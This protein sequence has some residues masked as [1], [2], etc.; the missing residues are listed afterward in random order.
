MA[1]ITEAQQTLA[2]ANEPKRF[3]L[4]GLIGNNALSLGMALIKFLLHMATS[5]NYG[6][7][8]DEF[9]YID[10]GKHLSSGYVDFPAFMGLIAAFAHMFFGDSLM[11]YRLFP[12]LAGALIVLLAGLITREVGGGTFAQFLVTLAMIISPQLLWLGSTLTTGAFDPLWWTVAIYILVLLIKRER[13]LL[14][15]VFGLVIGIGIA[16]KLTIFSL[17]AAVIPALLLTPQRKYLFNRWAWLGGAIAIAFLIPYLLWNASNGWPTVAFYHVYTRIP[18]NV[19]TFFLL[20]AFMESPILVPL[21]CIGLYSLFFGEKMSSYKVFGWIF[22]I[23]YVVFTIT[24]A[25]F[26]FLAPAYV[27]LLAAGSIVIERVTQKLRWRWIRPTYV[28]L[29]ALVGMVMMPYAIPVLPLQVLAHMY[30]RSG[31]K[32]V[33]TV[34]GQDP[35]RPQIPYGFEQEMGW[36]NMTATVA[37]V[38]HSLPANEQGKAC[39]LALKYAEAGALNYYSPQYHLPQV[40]SGHNS[41]YFW[42]PGNCTGEVIISLGY[43][44]DLLQRKF[45]TVKPAGVSTCQ[46][47]TPDFINVPIYICYHIKTSMKAEWSKFEYLA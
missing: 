16:T 41:Y 26:Y 32:H 47:C 44:P 31:G 42:G 40:I 38:Y 6:I 27:L 25:N 3:S 29:I 9:Y 2:P 19:F 46:Y 24:Q 7:F 37:R 20:Q 5:N 22:V 30:S 39:V 8:L 12:A 36:E 33:V 14:W 15:L 34:P 18:T 11:G 35:N 4:Q 1:T 28:A 45:S 13:P 17:G 43:P 23:L 21:W 10:A